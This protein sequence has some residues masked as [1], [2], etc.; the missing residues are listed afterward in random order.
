M[1]KTALTILIS[2]I[3]TIIIVS[4]V[5]VGTCL[6]F[7][8][9]QYNDYCE[10]MKVIPLNNNATELEKQSYNDQYIECTDRYNVASEEYNQIILSFDCL[11]RHRNKGFFVI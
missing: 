5:N 10:E 9:P 2:I 6:F 8:S 7:D 11:Q 3:L 4:T 1:N